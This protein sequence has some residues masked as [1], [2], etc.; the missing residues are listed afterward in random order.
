MAFLKIPIDTYVFGSSFE[1]T[2]T[3][4]MLPDV[5]IL[6]AIGGVCQDTDSCPDDSYVLL[7]QDDSTAAGYG[8]LQ[9]LTD[10]CDS[11]L[12]FL[13]Y[14]LMFGTV[15][16]RAGKTFLSNT[17]I[18]GATFDLMISQNSEQH[19]PAVTGGGPVKPQDT[20]YALRCKEWPCSAEERLT[21]PRK[22]NWPP[23]QLI[24]KMKG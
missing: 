13:L 4:G 18:R 12:K 9:L 7:V 1:G 8:K 2:S 15:N 16:D 3:D 6:H 23:P 10:R 22:Y 17:G 19:G 5:D 14:S 20:V 11:V 24:E 21:R